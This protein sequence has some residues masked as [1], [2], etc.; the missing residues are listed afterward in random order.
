MK[1]KF[2]LLCSVLPFALMIACAPMRFSQYSGAKRIWF[3]SPEALAETSFSLPVYR[4]WP[5][6]PYEVVGSVRFE[7]PRKD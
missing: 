6:K 5:D 1:T 4:S 7:D 2:F 3:V